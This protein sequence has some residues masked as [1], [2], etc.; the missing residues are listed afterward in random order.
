[1]QSRHSVRD[2]AGQLPGGARVAGGE[3]FEPGDRIPLDGGVGSNCLGREGVRG[4]HSETKEIARQ[5]EINGLPSPIGPKGEPPCRA[6]DNSVTSTR[7]TRPVDKSPRPADTETRGRAPP[8]FGVSI[9][10]SRPAR[11]ST[12]ARSYSGQLDL[13]PFQVLHRLPCR[14]VAVFF[15]SAKQHGDQRTEAT[16]CKITERRIA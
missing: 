9:E 11:A 16:F 6:R 12:L 15:G 4:V 8:A 10:G 2:D 5:Q 7:Q 1:M 13:R 3:T 14:R